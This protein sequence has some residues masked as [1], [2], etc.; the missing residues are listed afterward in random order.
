MQVGDRES[1]VSQ[2]Q[3]LQ[4]AHQKHLKW[5][6]RNS[7]RGSGVSQAWGQPQRTRC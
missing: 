2:A 1:S 6:W 3:A 7:E 5:P 4:V